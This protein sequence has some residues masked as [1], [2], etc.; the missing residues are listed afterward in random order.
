MPE[1]VAERFAIAGQAKLALAPTLGSPW[2][3]RHA[4]Q[5]VG[6][7]LWCY[8]ITMCLATALSALAQDRP[9]R[10]VEE[11]GRSELSLVEE[12]PAEVKTLVEKLDAPRFADR[13]DATRQL[14]A[15]GPKCI[16]LFTELLQSESRETRFRVS[17]V[18]RHAF[19]FDEIAP[20]LVRAVAK[21]YGSQ[22]RMILRDRALLQVDEVAELD[23][24]TKLFEFW[25][26]SAATLRR[27]VTFDLVDAQGP[28]QVGEVVAPLIG[29]SAKAS[30][31]NRYLSR[32]KDLSLAYDHRHSPGFVIAETLAKGLLEGDQQKTR[33]ARNY[34]DAFD[35]LVVNLQQEERAGSPRNEVSDRAN[36]SDGAA[37]FLARLLAAESDERDLMVDRLEIDPEALMGEFFHGLALA[38][39]AECYRCVGKVHIAD[40]LIESLTDW[41]NAPRDGVVESVVDCV[42]TTIASGDKP[43]ALALLDALNGCAKMETSGLSVSQ[44]LGQRLARRLCTAAL[45]ASDNRACY[46]VRA[47]HERILKVV[48]AGI[49]VDH[50]LF[51]TEFVESYLDAR[52]EAVSDGAR[53]AL[54]RYV[55]ILEKLREAGMGWDDEPVGQFVEQMKSELLQE[56]DV[57]KEGLEKLSQ[58]LSDTKS[59]STDERAERIAAALK[60]WRKM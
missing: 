27:R 31:F 54:D 10:Q 16:P 49:G 4:R 18:L 47:I 21:P 40:M 38:D 56:T 35:Q 43:K 53:L 52:D 22:A 13:N 44:G 45:V 29:L 9:A 60:T 36:M 17:E 6:I 20:H 12:L 26:T 41:P 15:Q 42:K 46:P 57:L 33:F 25:G 7:R 50:R 30:L 19:T 3:V 1:V 39:T 34:V 37:C 24:T 51:P 28:E 58:L 55:T 59:L 8:A 5:A 2:A 14:V 11:P 23:N 48:D 32:L